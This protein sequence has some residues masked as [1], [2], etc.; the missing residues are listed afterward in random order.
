M[1]EYYNDEDGGGARI[2]LPEPITA[3]RKFVQLY[4]HE[5][6]KIKPY[7]I[8]DNQINRDHRIILEEALTQRFGII[9]QISHEFPLLNGKDY[10]CVGAGD[11]SVYRD[12]IDIEGESLGYKKD[13]GIILKPNKPHL[14]ELLPFFPKDKKIKLNGELLE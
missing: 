1:E 14:I 2:V 12:S 11:V 13:L 3:Y 4:I 9:P 5:F 10:E 8:S 6:Q 7:F